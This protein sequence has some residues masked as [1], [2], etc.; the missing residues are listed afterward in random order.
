MRGMRSAG[1]GFVA[2]KTAEAA[3]KAV[4]ELDKKEL[5]GRQIIVEVAKAPEQKDKDRKEKKARRRPG[6][7]GSPSLSCSSR[8]S[9]TR[10]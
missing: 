3:E 6:R 4:A 1:Y 7:R 10:A 8:S 2:L 5:D 9:A